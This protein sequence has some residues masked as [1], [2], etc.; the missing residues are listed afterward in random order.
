MRE[1]MRFFVT[2]AQCKMEETEG[3][4]TVAQ[5][6]IEALDADQ[7]TSQDPILRKIIDEYRNAADPSAINERHYIDMDDAGVASFVASAVGGRQHLSK[8]HSKYSV[9]KDEGEMLDTLVPRAVDELRMRV[10]TQM[11]DALM[12]RL[13]AS[14]EAGA[15]EEEIEEEMRQLADLNKVKRSFSVDRLGERAIIKGAHPSSCAPRRWPSCSHP[16]PSS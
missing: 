11:I 3:K 8:I 2:Y 4:P 1:V 6:I 9:V 15:P 13:N 16:M 7:I 5:Y 12:A 10:L 14:V